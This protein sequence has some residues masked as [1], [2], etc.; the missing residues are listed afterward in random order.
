MVVVVLGEVVVVVV[1]T[2]CGPLCLLSL[3]Q[4]ALQ[5]RPPCPCSLFPPLL[6]AYAGFGHLCGHVVGVSAPPPPPP[7]RSQVR[8]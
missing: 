2:T 1:C 5:A 3:A 8:R 6:P 4:P 7:C